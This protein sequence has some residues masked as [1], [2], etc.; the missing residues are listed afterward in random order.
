[1]AGGGTGITIAGEVNAEQQQ[2][3]ASIGGRLG[4]QFNF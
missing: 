2:S 3:H 1:L 4:L